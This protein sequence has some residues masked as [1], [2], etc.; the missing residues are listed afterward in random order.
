M[1]LTWDSLSLN[2]QDAMEINWFP[3]TAAISN[4]QHLSH[5][6]LMRSCGCGCGQ[7]WSGYQAQPS[8]IH[9]QCTPP[10]E[11]SQTLSILT[12]QQQMKQISLKSK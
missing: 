2:D 3:P 10:F 9:A 1:A 8:D 4:N 12:I 11:I 5:H 6:P 7:E